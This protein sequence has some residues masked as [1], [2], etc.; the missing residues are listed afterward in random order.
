MLC[1]E[2][3]LADVYKE[4][5]MKAVVSSVGDSAIV[6]APNSNA[7][8]WMYE[9]HK[10]SLSSIECFY[11]SASGEYKTT[12]NWAEN[13][14]YPAGGGIFI[15]VS[16]ADTNVSAKF[17]FPDGDPD[18]GIWGEDFLQLN[19]RVGKTIKLVFDPPPRQLLIKKSRQY[20]HVFL[21]KEA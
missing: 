19:N 11:R 8:Y 5:H 2:F 20:L 10:C 17:R 21:K 4:C 3:L 9:G 18:E 15:T 7:P 14:I 13:N 6:F 12:W 16:D 1:K